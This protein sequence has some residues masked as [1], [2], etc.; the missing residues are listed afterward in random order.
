MQSGC[1]LSPF[2]YSL[3][4]HDC[5]PVHGSNTIIKFVDDTMVIGLIKDNDEWAYKEEVEQLAV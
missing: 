5:R 1:V 4:I 2:R 3:F